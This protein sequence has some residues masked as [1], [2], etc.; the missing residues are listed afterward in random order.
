MLEQFQ[1]AFPPFPTCAVLP[2]N[3]VMIVFRAFSFREAL[4]YSA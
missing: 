2:R 1:H 3:A 4:Q